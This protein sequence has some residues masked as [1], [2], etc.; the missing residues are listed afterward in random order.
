MITCWNCRGLSNS[1]QYL[2]E[3]ISDG[4]D[5]VLSDHWLWPF[6]LHGLEETHPD[7]MSWGQ[8]DSRLIST[9][10]STR[11]CDGVGVIWHR[12]SVVQPCIPG[13]DSDRIY[14]IRI[15]IKDSQQFLSIIAV[16]LPCADLGTDYYR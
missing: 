2:N 16:Y 3:L 4:S 11:R 7:F 1:T 15:K 5:L 8:A 14:G 6:E 12:D 13:S 10:D 9:S